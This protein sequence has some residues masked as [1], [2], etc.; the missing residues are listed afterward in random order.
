MAD[1]G[2]IPDLMEGLHENLDNND[3]STNT[4]YALGNMA[5]ANPNN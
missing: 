1:K 2:I 3:V 5:H 4:T